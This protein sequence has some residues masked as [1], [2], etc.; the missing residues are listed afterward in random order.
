MEQYET[1]LSICIPTYNR[2]KILDR[3]LENIERELR[4]IDTNE[5]EFII[6]NN[7]STDNTESVIQKYIERGVPIK[8]ICNERNIGADDNIVQCFKKGKGKY[9]WVL[10]DDDFLKEGALKTIINNI[11]E[12]DYGL[13]HLEAKSKKNRI[14]T[15]YTEVEEFMKDISFWITFITS[16][17]VNSKFVSQIDFEKYRNTCFYQIPLYITAAK[18]SKTNLMIH[19]KLFEE[20]KDVKNSGG[21]NFFETFVINYLTIRKELLID[22]RNESIYYEKEKKFFFEKF[23]IYTIYKFYFWRDIGKFNID[24]GWKILIKYYGKNLYFYTGIL[25]YIPK[26]IIRKIFNKTSNFIQRKE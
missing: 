23:L 19:Q 2:A 24:N 5:I 3:A 21:Y 15:E 9:I 6:S 16:H 4:T 14:S 10:G 22:T 1:I 13:I 17:I 18:K 12:K 11:Q 8:Y 25:F 7:C 26:S 20:A